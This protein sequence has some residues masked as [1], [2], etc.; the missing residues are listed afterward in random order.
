[1]NGIATNNNNYLAF[2]FTALGMLTVTR[3]SS[4]PAVTQIN[5]TELGVDISKGI[6]LVQHWQ[7]DGG[8]Q[9]LDVYVNEVP[10]M[11]GSTRSPMQTTYTRISVAAGAPAP[12]TLSEIYV[13]AGDPLLS[14]KVQD[15]QLAVDNAQAVY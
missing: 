1:T 6:D 2:A 5:L 15:C 10:V 12:A 8:V 7:Y 13:K 4:S 9:I 3:G 11:L 14:W